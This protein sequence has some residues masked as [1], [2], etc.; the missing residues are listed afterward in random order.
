[1]VWRMVSRMVWRVAPK[2]RKVKSPKSRLKLKPPPVRLPPS[3]LKPDRRKSGN[4]QANIRTAYRVA[5]AGGAAGVRNADLNVDLN[6][7]PS[8]VRNAE[9]NVDQNVAQIV[10]PKVAAPPKSANKRYLA[11]WPVP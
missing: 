2:T 7:D 4:A 8:V 3:A 9:L 5:C 6:A 1:M 11:R 10:V